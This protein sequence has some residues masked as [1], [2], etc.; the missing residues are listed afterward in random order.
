MVEDFQ[1]TW[2]SK[3]SIDV[4]GTTTDEGTPACQGQPYGTSGCS[5]T[6][7]PDFL[8]GWSQSQGLNCYEGYGATVVA[9]EP[10]S[11]QSGEGISEVACMA[12][13][14]VSTR[15]CTA[16]V[17]SKYGDC[18][19]R[20]DVD[21]TSCQQQDDFSLW[22][23]GSEPPSPVPT[24]WE[25]HAGKN[26]YAGNGAETK[27]SEPIVNHDLSLDQCKSKCTE[28]NDC[29]GITFPR[30]SKKGGKCFLRFNI[31]VDQCD[32]GSDWDTWEAPH[33]RNDKLM[34]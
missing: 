3:T 30:R 5:V 29:T 10:Y 14:A 34:V 28:E 15:P 26:C 24:Q 31:V 25:R 1:G 2:G 8:P 7:A 6:S 19:L 33:F 18:Y 20:T 16:V 4:F 27:W 9:P 32:E 13:C 21:V 12:A 17:T 11:P 22:M 23:L